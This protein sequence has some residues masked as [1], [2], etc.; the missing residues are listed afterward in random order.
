LGVNNWKSV[1]LNGEEWRAILR[2]ARAHKGAVAPM[3]M[4]M[5]MPKNVHIIFQILYIMGRGCQQNDKLSLEDGDRQS[6]AWLRLFPIKPTGE[7]LSFSNPLNQVTHKVGT[8]SLLPRLFISIW[9]NTNFPSPLL[10]SLQSLK[11]FLALYQKPV[12]SSY[13]LTTITAE[14]LLPSTIV[15]ITWLSKVIIPEDG[16]YKSCQSVGKPSLVAKI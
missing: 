5:M 9:L 10:V 3:M 14:K 4:M 6:T 13:L 2:K 12:S 1:A 11:I 15:L 8:M 7:Q 16:N